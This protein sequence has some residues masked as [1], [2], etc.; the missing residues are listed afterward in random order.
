MKVEMPKNVI[1]IS[2]Y[3]RGLYY[4]YVYSYIFHG[5]NENLG[6]I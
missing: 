4:M 5:F 3:K 6:K 2:A 1:P